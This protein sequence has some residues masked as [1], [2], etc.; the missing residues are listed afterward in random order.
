[1]KFSC[2]RCGKRYSTANEPG[3]GRV[4]R[5]PCPCGNTI[6]LCADVAPAACAPSL[7]P[8][9]QAATPPVPPPL[10]GSTRRP[11]A[12]SRDATVAAPI[13][14]RALVRAPGAARAVVGARAAA[15]RALA[16]IAA[17]AAGARWRVRSALAR[18]SEHAALRRAE[19]LVFCGRIP[20]RWPS[21]LGSAAAIAVLAVAVRAWFAVELVPAA[22]AATVVLAPEPAAAQTACPPAPAIPSP[23]ADAPPPR[24]PE[25]AGPGVR[26]TVAAGAPVAPS[27]AE[28]TDTARSRL[29]EA[30]AAVTAAEAALAEAQA[31]GGAAGEA[32]APG[33]S[34][35][36]PATPSPEAE[37]LEPQPAP[38]P[39][40]GPVSSEPAGPARVGDELAVAGAPPERR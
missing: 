17:A 36:A 28:P 18:L 30:E 19:A 24:S 33:T 13:G 29:A 20:S 7:A 4:Y 26:I 35:E 37:R 21:L 38:A 8:A 32:A 34:A 10:P 39:A 25:D 3:S 23:P 11:A 14:Y 9:G 22:S 16:S 15:G 40:T 31:R 27:Q 5:I 1:M 2:E 12:G 6:I